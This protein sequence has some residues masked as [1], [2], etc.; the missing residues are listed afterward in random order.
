MSIVSY[1]QIVNFS[2]LFVR[3]FREIYPTSPFRSLFCTVNSSL[4]FSHS[5]F[6]MCGDPFIMRF[7]D[8][9][10]NTSGTPP[11]LDE[12][13]KFLNV[14]QVTPTL[15]Q[16]IPF[17]MLFTLVFPVVPCHVYLGTSDSISKTEKEVLSTPR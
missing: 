2:D 14:P 9:L 12:Q 10:V 11:T 16:P 8:L 1:L 17:S 7:F 5:S 13:S 6:S 15:F 4:Y 3:T